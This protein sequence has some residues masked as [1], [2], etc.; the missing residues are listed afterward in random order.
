MATPPVHSI[1]L[2][3]MTKCMWNPFP[4]CLSASRKIHMAW[5]KKQ[6]K[7]SFNTA[8]KIGT[9]HQRSQ[10]MHFPFIHATSTPWGHCVTEVHEVPNGWVQKRSRRI[11]SLDTKMWELCGLCA[12]AMADGA[13]ISCRTTISMT[14][15]TAPTA[16]FLAL[17]MLSFLGSK[18]LDSFPKN[19]P[20][21]RSDNLLFWILHHS[22]VPDPPEE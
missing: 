8:E 12:R 3:E 20:R 18:S 22:Y 2:R 19:S 7:K 10:A 14:T 5:K 21:L 11:P 15:V 4:C 6:K 16:C 9:Y 1:Y 13:V 17:S